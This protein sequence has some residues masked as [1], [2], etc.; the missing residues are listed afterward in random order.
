M[1]AAWWARPSTWVEAFFRLTSPQLDPLGP[2]TF[3]Y[4]SCPSNS[5]GWPSTPAVSPSNTHALKRGLYTPA[6]ESHLSVH[7]VHVSPPRH[8]PPLLLVV[9]GRLR[10]SQLGRGLPMLVHGVHML[11]PTTPN[12]FPS[13]FKMLCCFYFPCFVFSDVLFC[14][15]PLF[16]M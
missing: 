12:P 3:G 9:F 16:S 5:H 15:F 8:P 10:R 11:A 4:S 14:V 2:S 1:Y 6:N 7:E 13:K